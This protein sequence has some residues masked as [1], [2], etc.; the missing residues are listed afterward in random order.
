MKEADLLSSVID[1]AHVYHW[2]VAHFRPAKTDKGWRTA[3]QGDGKGFPDLVLV[4]PPRVVVMELKGKK[5]VV[6][7]EQLIWLKEFAQCNVEA[8]VFSPDDW[9]EIRGVLKEDAVD[10][11][12][13]LFK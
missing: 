10:S 11:N 7:N 6:R 5:A 9:D 13:V 4:R 2:R 1:L 12:L 8:F 3:V